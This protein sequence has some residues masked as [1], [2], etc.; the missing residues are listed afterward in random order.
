MD[1]FEAAALSQR[2]T[3]VADFTR[4]AI[5]LA[6]AKGD[7]LQARE[8]FRSRWPASK[9]LPMIEKAAV[10]AGTTTET[11]WAAPL[12]ELDHL[13]SAFTEA[14]RP[15]T[16][17]GRLTGAR[18]VP[19][20]VKTPRTPFGSA[21][22]WVGEGK[23]LAATGL[24]FATITLEP[25]KVAAIIVSTVELSRFADPSA[26]DLIRRDLLAAA[27]HFLDTALVDP[28]AT[29]TAT[30][31]AS[32]TNAATSFVSSGNT[33]AAV[34]AD[35]R[36]LLQHLASA[37]IPFR[38]PF[39]I[40]H[41]R[42]AAGLAALRT[43]DGAAAFPTISVTGG[44]LMGVPVIVSGAVPDAQ[45]SPAGGSSLIAIDASQLLIGEGRLGIDVARH[46]SLQ[47]DTAP[48]D[49][50]DANTVLTDLW[51]NNLVGF[52]VIAER[53]WALTDP[54]AVAVLENIDV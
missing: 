31:P 50:A 40:L 51:S 38:S 24:S 29:A 11:S 37:D 41:P 23:P 9:S 49:P 39:F 28:A 27:A 47:M 8:V 52:R 3:R 19:L 12:A 17:A 30:S 6:I 26:E 10:A 14:L 35:L 48:D 7:P 22:G 42:I 15:Q 36:L 18:R 21:V 5:A 34:A 46:A 25:F 54:D 44:T 13:G 1:P 33:P 53:N 16:I 32:I 43:T 4:W 20:N 45:G 2:S